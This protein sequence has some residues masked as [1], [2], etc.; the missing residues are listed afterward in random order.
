MSSNSLYNGMTSLA[1]TT[2]DGVWLGTTGIAL[3]KGAFKVTNAGVLTATSGTVGGWTI[4][5]NQLNSGSGA[6]Y[7]ALNSAASDTNA[8]AMWAGNSA[9]ASAPFSVTKA[10]AL[11]ASSADITGAIHA[12][13]LVI[14]SGAQSA[15][16]GITNSLY[17]DKNTA[18][19][20]SD[21]TTA[22]SNTISGKMDSSSFTQGNII[23]AINGNTNTTTID[24]GKI[25]TGSITA[26]KIAAGAITT[27]TLTAS[28]VIDASQG[29]N[30]NTKVDGN[31][32]QIYFTR[33]GVSGKS[34]NI[35]L[36][37]DGSGYLAA[38]NISWDRNGGFNL[39][40]GSSGRYIRYNP[41]D[42]YLDAVISSLEVDNGVIIGGDTSING[43]LSVSDATIGSIETTGNVSIGGDLEVSG[44]ISGSFGALSATSV[45]AK[46]L[47][48]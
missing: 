4:G 35:E 2:H 8:Y 15:I 36:N 23:K 45:T 16:T 12:T 47:T 48:V 29:V 40:S 1:D 20:S 30:S 17:R 10:G 38:S 3:G 7:V 13:S 42:G 11:K 22:L 24:G 14:D 18:I 19:G 34:G 6:S 26:D 5:A 9:A 31:G 37:A 28:K 32:V 39:T 43:E 41:T 44:T 46:G 27:N 25:T 21:L 33:E